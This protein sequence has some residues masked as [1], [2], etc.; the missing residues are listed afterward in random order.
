MERRDEYI[1]LIVD[2]QMKVEKNNN[3]QWRERQQQAYQIKEF[4]SLISQEKFNQFY[5]PKFFE[6][7]LDEVAQVREKVA[8]H[9]TASILHAFLGTSYL[10]EFI[11]QMKEFKDSNR[12]NFRQTFVG[13]I[14]SIFLDFCEEPKVDLIQEIIFKYFLKDLMDIST[15]RVV[16]VRL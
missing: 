13:M 5:V 2:A 8:I 15:D 6:L 12:Y 11:N 3:G 9:S 16:N 10:Q 7:C 1:E 14:E 4:S